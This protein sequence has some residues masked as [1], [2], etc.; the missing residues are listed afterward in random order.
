MLS[1]YVLTYVRMY[2]LCTTM[3]CVDNLDL[4]RVANMAVHRTHG[5]S[6]ASYLSSDIFLLSS[7]LCIFRL[8]WQ[9]P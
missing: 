5:S 3:Y 7:Y 9:F 2:R 8:K 1:S 4:A 6:L